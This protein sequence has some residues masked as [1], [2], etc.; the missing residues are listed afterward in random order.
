VCKKF[1]YANSEDLCDTIIPKKI[2]EITWKAKCI[3]SSCSKSEI[4]SLKP[5]HIE[6][7]EFEFWLAMIG[8]FIDFCQ[9]N[10]CSSR[11]LPLDLASSIDFDLVKS[12]LGS[13]CEKFTSV[14]N[15]PFCAYHGNATTTINI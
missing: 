6:N 7:G 9:P 10:F 4:Y 8:R 14:G 15:Y 5:W 3:G 1:L 12:Y 11:F 2:V 13:L